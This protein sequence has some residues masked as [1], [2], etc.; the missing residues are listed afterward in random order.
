MSD[1]I[2]SLCQTKINETLYFFKGKF[3]CRACYTIIKYI[4]KI[5]NVKD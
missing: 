5:N 2:C 3:Y 1:K 4:R